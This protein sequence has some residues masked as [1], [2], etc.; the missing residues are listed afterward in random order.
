MTTIVLLQVLFI[1][2]MHGVADF[3]LQT[4]DMALGK[5]SSNYWLSLHV[6][7]YALGIT[8]VAMMLWGFIGYHGQYIAMLWVLINAGLH[9]ITDYYTSRWTKRLRE[10]EKYYGFPS[11][12]MVIELD[13]LIHYTCLFVTYS[14]F[15][16]KF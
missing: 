8:P 6:F 12:F 4:K 10:Q 5:S 13:Q 2:V 7:Y 16:S 9:W 1:L 3:L 15:V 14:Y 11:F